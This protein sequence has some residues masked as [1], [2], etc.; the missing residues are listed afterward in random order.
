M[1][2]EHYEMMETIR[3]VQMEHLDIRTVTMGISL[4]DCID[5][6]FEQMKKKVY[7]K[8]TTKANSL[9]QVADRVGKQY[10]IPIINKRISITPAAELLGQATKEEAV[11]LAKTLDKA[12]RELEIDFIGGYSALVHKGMT[13]G[14]NTLLAALPE[15]LAVTERVCGSVSVASTRAGMN[16]EAIRQ[17]G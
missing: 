1:S 10:G 5:P 3:M 14:D 17:M 11:Q 4:Y 12:A 8:I 16:M 15:A 6:D 9:K 7:N 2:I 13:K